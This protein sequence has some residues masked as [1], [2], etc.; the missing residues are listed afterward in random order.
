[1]RK[2]API[3]A[4]G[5]EWKQC[6]IHTHT[7]TMCFLC[8]LCR[9]WEIHA[10]AVLSLSIAAKGKFAQKHCYGKNTQINI[11]Q[12]HSPV[13]FFAFCRRIYWA[14]WYNKT[15]PSTWLEHFELSTWKNIM[16]LL[17]VFVCWSIKQPLFC[18]CLVFFLN[19][20]IYVNVSNRVRVF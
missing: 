1:M 9:T 4:N 16:C 12:K 18:C 8:T 17:V 15:H 7:H 3:R 2:L 13:C 14:N 19:E 10:S 6:I 5:E 11:H 20:N